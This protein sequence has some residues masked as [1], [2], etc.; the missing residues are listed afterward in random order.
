MPNPRLLLLEIKQ[1]CGR[2]AKI[3]DD[4]LSPIKQQR[5]KEI[6]Q[7]T[8]TTMVSSSRSSSASSSD[9]SSTG[10][11]DETASTYSV[12]DGEELKESSSNNNNNNNKEGGKEMQV[13]KVGEEAERD[14]F[15]ISQVF[16]NAWRDALHTIRTTNW[17]DFAISCLKSPRYNTVRERRCTSTTYSSIT[18][19]QF[20]N[21]PSL[22]FI[23]KVLGG[24]DIV[25]CRR[26]CLWV[27]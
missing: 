11:L 20:Y 18:Y 24:F 9:D 12:E 1:L 8:T 25:Y 10:S 27:E 26:S 14:D 19:N 4:L 17:K 15:T 21:L 3:V 22:L 7:A 5:R 23:N 16:Q 2:D 6:K 13:S